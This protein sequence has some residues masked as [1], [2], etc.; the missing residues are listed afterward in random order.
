M[1]NSNSDI[2][3]NGSGDSVLLDEVFTSSEIDPIKLFKRNYRIKKQGFMNTQKK[4][5]DEVMLVLLKRK[6]PSLLLFH[7]NLLTFDSSQNL[8]KLLFDKPVFNARHIKI[9]KEKKPIY[10]QYDFHCFHCKKI[11]NN[12]NFLL[13]HWMNHHVTDFSVLS[14]DKTKRGNILVKLN[15]SPNE[16]EQMKK[17]KFYDIMTFKEVPYTNLSTFSAV[18][19]FYSFSFDEMTEKEKQQMR[20]WV[21]KTGE[22]INRK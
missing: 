19:L 1:N 9:V 8:P 12:I 13:E 3:L 11:W 6:Y 10:V 20:K 15:A 22:D 14:I 4:S 7:N 5:L 17:H 21:E 18:N 2:D 16:Y